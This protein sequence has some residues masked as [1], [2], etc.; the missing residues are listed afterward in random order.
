MKIKKGQKLME[1]LLATGK[2]TSILCMCLH[3]YKTINEILKN[4]NK[5]INSTHVPCFC[6][7]ISSVFS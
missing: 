6:F 5:N 2:A 3:S 7:V 1:T 4:R